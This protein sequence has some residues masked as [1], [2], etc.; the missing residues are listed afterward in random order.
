MDNK[1]KPCPFCGKEVKE[2]DNSNSTTVNV[3]ECVHCKVRFVFPCSVISDITGDNYI[4]TFNKRCKR[5]TE[6]INGG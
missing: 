5:G 1:L 6:M 4:Q 2:W 3:I